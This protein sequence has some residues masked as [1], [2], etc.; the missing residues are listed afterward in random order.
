MFLGKREKKIFSSSLNLF[1]FTELSMFI[2]ESKSHDNQ[3]NKMKIMECRLT[4]RDFFF[5][6]YHT[7]NYIVITQCVWLTCV[8]ALMWKRLKNFCIGMVLVR[9]WLSPLT[10]TR[11]WLRLDQRVSYVNPSNTSAVLC[12]SPHFLSIFK[13][14][15]LSL[16][17][18]VQLCLPPTFFTVCNKFFALF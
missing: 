6:L 4:Y 10:K 9:L 18:H 14:T 3:Y 11:L 12:H 7:I 17:P 8:S 16:S 5:P 2:I 13:A 15:A 1:S